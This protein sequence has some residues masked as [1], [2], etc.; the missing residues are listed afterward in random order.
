MKPSPATRQIGASSAAKHMIKQTI[1]K[2]W[3]TNG[4]GRMASIALTSL[5]TGVFVANNV[6]LLIFVTNI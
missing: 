6:K 4:A 1:N 5:L 2:P 3:H